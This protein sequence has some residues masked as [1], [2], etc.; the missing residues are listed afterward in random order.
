MEVKQQIKDEHHHCL[1]IPHSV[2]FRTGPMMISHKE[3][4]SQH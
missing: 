3:E 1:Q 2:G 4:T